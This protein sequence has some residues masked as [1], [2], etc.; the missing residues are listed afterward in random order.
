MSTRWDS[1]SHHVL[2]GAAG[3]LLYSLRENNNWRFWYMIGIMQDE[4]NHNCNNTF[5]STISFQS[6]TE[7]ALLLKQDDMDGT[8]WVYNQKLKEWASNATARVMAAFKYTMNC[9]GV[10]R[11]I[12]TQYMQSR[13]QAAKMVANNEN[14]IW[15]ELA[16]GSQWTLRL[17]IYKFWRDMKGIQLLDCSEMQN[18]SSQINWKVQG[19]QSPPKADKCC[20]WCCKQF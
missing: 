20:H 6:S 4:F 19:L 15:N 16:S 13:M 11:S 12:V 2:M 3:W 8:Y 18:N 10:V 9:H 7:M 14:T 17:K 1:S 5:N